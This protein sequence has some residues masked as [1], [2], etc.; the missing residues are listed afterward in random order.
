MARQKSEAKR[1]AILDAALGEFLSNGVRASRVEDIARL[2]GVAK[3]TLYL[4]FPSKE[5]L[6]AALAEDLGTYVADRMRAAAAKPGNAAQRMRFVFDEI[7]SDGGSRYAR[8]IRLLWAEG[9]HRPE[10]VRPFAK[11]FVL[12]AWGEGGYAR[13]AAA[14]ATLPGELRRYP[15]LLVAPIVMALIWQ[16]IVGED[17]PLDF[18]G[19]Y[20]AYLQVLGRAAREPSRQGD[21]TH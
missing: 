14:A 2:A 19:M 10:M 6:L 11:R 4:Y 8:L 15:Q 21:P 12:P 13:E 3:G 16:S 18:R 1:A 20:D 5:S 9:L 17:M 7:L